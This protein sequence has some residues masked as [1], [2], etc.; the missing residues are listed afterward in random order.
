MVQIFTLL[1][2]NVL[3]THPRGGWTAAVILLIKLKENIYVVWSSSKCYHTG[4][5]WNGIAILLLVDDLPQ[6]QEPL[7]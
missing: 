1:M 4:H 2:A 6:G 5:D 3:K 7:R